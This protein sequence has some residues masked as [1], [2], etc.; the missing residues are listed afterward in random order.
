MTLL[1]TLAQSTTFVKFAISLNV[2][3]RISMVAELMISRIAQS[4]FCVIAQYKF[5]MNAQLALLPP[6]SP[7]RFAHERSAQ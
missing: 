7:L 4:T 6:V 2:P 1:P 5:L 3:L